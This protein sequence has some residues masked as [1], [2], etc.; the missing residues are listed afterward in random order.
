MITVF[1]PAAFW[2][3]ADPSIKENYG[4]VTEAI[5]STRK[6]KSLCEQHLQDV[7]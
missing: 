7:K 5:T 6:A 3:A 1:A 4:G 2:N